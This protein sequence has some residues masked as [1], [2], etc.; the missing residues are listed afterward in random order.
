MAWE[1]SCERKWVG[2]G[3]WVVRVWYGTGSGTKRSTPAQHCHTAHLC[4]NLQFG[5]RIAQQAASNSYRL[6]AG[7]SQ[8]KSLPSNITAVPQR[9]ATVS[10]AGGNLLQIEREGG[11][12]VTSNPFLDFQLAA[13]KHIPT[14]TQ[15]SRKQ[16]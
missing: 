13:A 5:A 11:L 7:S 8:A 2:G 1:Q 15:Q 4:Q 16:L 9:A 6:P 12:K 10:G 14:I 3:T